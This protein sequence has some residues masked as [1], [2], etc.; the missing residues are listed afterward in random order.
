MFEQTREVEIDI[1]VGSGEYVDVE[2]RNLLNHFM[3]R[4]NLNDLVSVDSI[5]QSPANILDNYDTE[6]L[7]VRGIVM[8]PFVAECL[9]YIRGYRGDDLA[10]LLEDR[11]DFSAFNIISNYS[12]RIVTKDEQS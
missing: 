7:F 6:N 8:M 2:C 9:Q 12:F 1:V 3:A 5:H 10:Q 4:H 11:P